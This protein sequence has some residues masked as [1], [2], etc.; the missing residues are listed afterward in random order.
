VEAGKNS[1]F[2]S[3]RKRKY[4][5]SK[6][7]FTECSFFSFTSAIGEHKLTSILELPTPHLFDLHFASLGKSFQ[8]FQSL[9]KLC[10]IL[11]IK[12]YNTVIYLF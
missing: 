4:D 2:P 10:H 8:S 11:Q 9:E 6:L 5:F 3:P 12:L 7:S 1:Q